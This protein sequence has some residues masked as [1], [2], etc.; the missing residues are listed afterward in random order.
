MLS[1]PY[2]LCSKEMFGILHY[3]LDHIGIP[4]SQFMR[5]CLSSLLEYLKTQNGILHKRFTSMSFDHHCENQRNFET[6]FASV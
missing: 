1:I 6:I 4:V 5:E 2:T 3:D